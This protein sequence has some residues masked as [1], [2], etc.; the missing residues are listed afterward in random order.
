[1][2]LGGKST[3]A[4]AIRTEFIE[5]GLHKIEALDAGGGGRDERK[6]L[7]WGRRRWRKV[8]TTAAESTATSATAAAWTARHD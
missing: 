8:C 7:A 1:V 6:Y 4:A 3:A 5:D 2:K